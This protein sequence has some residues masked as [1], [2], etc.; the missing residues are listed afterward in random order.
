MTQTPMGSGTRITYVDLTDATEEAIGMG[1]RFLRGRR[2]DIVALTLLVFTCFGLAMF[3]FSPPARV[4]IVGDL[5]MLRN[6]FS[7]L[8]LA[9]FILRILVAIFAFGCFTYGWLLLT[10][11]SFAKENL[12][13]ER[14]GRTPRVIDELGV[15][16]REFWRDVHRFR[17]T[18]ERQAGS[19]PTRLRWLSRILQFLAGL[20]ALSPIILTPF[21]DFDDWLKAKGDSFLFWAEGIAFMLYLVS[22][23]LRVPPV[24]DWS[25]RARAWMTLLT[26]L[27]IVAA[28]FGVTVAG[29]HLLEALIDSGLFPSSQT[30]KIL[31]GFIHTARRRVGLWLGGRLA[32]C[33]VHRCRLHTARPKNRSCSG[34]RSRASRSTGAHHGPTLLRR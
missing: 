26:G 16:M 27:G 10:R 23:R 34:T 25:Y 5:A 31:C 19:K 30:S 18:L 6:D 15:S 12:Y 21:K 33:P 28:F 8:S 17:E 3:A 11:R 14:R 20:I 9:S 22:R 1:G 24:G 7:L 13:W 29:A 4:Q 32:P 2:K